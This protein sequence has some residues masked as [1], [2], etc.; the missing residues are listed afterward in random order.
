[1]AANFAAIAAGD[2]ECISENIGK[3]LS[4]NF[5]LSHLQRTLQTITW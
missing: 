5:S 4:V 1:L 3:F 2:M